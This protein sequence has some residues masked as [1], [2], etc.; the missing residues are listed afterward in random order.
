MKRFASPLYFLLAFLLIACE[1]TLHAQQSQDIQLAD[2]YFRNGEFDKAVVLYEKLWNKTPTNSQFYNNYLRCLTELKQYDEA[3]K[4]VRKQQKRF[5]DD[6]TFYVDLGSVYELEGK[7]KEATSQY[8]EAVE[9]I[10]PNMPQV[11]KLANRFQSAGLNDYAIQAYL[12]GRKVFNAF[13]SD[14]FLRELATLYRKQGDVSNAIKAYLD[15]VQFN[16]DQ[17]DEI[18]GQLQPLIDNNQ[19][20]KELQAELYRRIQKQPENE[21]YSDLLVW[22]FIQKKDFASAFT[23]VKALD[24]R[25]KEEGQRVFQFAQSA[26][27]EGNYDAALMAFRYLI[28]EKGKNSYMYLPARMGELNTEKT[29]ITIT[30]KYTSDDLSQLETKYEDFLNEFGKNQQTLTVMRDYAALESRY[31]HNIDKSLAILQEAIEIGTNDRKLNGYL[32]LDLGDAY[33]IKNQVWD[34][35]IY[36]GQVDKAFH[37]EPLGEEA[38]YKNAKLSFYMGDFEWSQAQLNVLKSATTELVANDALS[39]SV[40]ITD[41]MGLDTTPE[42]MKM[43]ARADLLIFQNRFDDAVKSLDSLTDEY[44]NHAL[45]DDVLFEKGRIYLQ[46]QKFTEAAAMFDKIDENYSFDLLGDD[47]LFQLA[48]LEQN[49]LNDKDK[50]ME[51]YKQILTKYKGSIYTVEARKRYRELRGD[52]LN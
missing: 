41:N 23:Q 5:P 35:M 30:N 7:D 6:L 12:K 4:T 49:Y 18:E 2:Q 42:P 52:E 43:Y 8:Q 21:N 9:K 47:A 50:A 13:N 24:K 45:H 17:L 16:P 14:L 38:R 1:G 37:D 33:L 26:F 34:A 31:I 48:E 27:D 44:P 22:Y 20:A 32:K 29:K 3:E 46:Q 10:T 40:F 25:N 15:I 51:L 19:Y 39:L 28:A 11:S 36:Y